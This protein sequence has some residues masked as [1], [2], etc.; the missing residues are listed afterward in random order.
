MLDDS[1]LTQLALPAAGERE[2]DASR[3]EFLKT[4]IYNKG[5]GCFVSHWRVSP[6]CSILIFF[7]SEEEVS[8][9]SWMRFLS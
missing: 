2:D 1:A 3:A 6:H 9:A 7:L 4:C 8:S 5:K